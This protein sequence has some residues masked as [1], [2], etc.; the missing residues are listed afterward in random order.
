MLSIVF[1]KIDKK[2]VENSISMVMWK[3][4]KAFVQQL[5]DNLFFI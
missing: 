1:M 5:L 4:F 2:V 3:Y